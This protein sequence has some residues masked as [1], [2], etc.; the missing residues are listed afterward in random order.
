MNEN[1]QGQIPTPDVHERVHGAD[2]QNGPDD[3]SEI[4]AAHVLQ[5]ERAESDRRSQPCAPGKSLNLVDCTRSPQ[6]LLRAG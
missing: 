1:D 3:V 4:P 5:D 2:G 6:Q